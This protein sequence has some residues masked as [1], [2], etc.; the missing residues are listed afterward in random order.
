M[1]HRHISIGCCL[2]LII[3]TVTLDA[4]S[5]D[6]QSTASPLDALQ[7][8]MD[9]LKQDM[10]E[11]KKALSELRLLMTQ[12]PVAPAQAAAPV[13]TRLS[14]GKSPSLGKADAPVTLVEFSD[15]QCPF[16]QR[17]FTTALAELKK[18]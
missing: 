8:D 10:A 3:A 16:C 4:P 2:M 13:V 14:V 7:Q 11:I 9:S 18:D 15:Y 6:A 12:R 17:H 1:A 5:A